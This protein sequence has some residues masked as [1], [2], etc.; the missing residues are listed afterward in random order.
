MIDDCLFYSMTNKG[1]HFWALLCEKQLVC[2]KAENCSLDP[3][4]FSTNKS[5]IDK[6]EGE[7]E[8]VISY[9]SSVIVAMEKK[10][11]TYLV[12]N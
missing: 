9:P 7:H 3:D 6:L 2:Q 11:D 4:I 1:V 5:I 8:Y 10:F 12:F